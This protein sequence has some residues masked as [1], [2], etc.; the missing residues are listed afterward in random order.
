MDQ[1]NL[2]TLSCQFDFIS[3]DCS[4]IQKGNQT[5]LKRN[6]RGCG[7]RGRLAIW[8]ASAYLFLR[9]L[10][11]NKF[12]IIGTSPAAAASQYSQ[13]NLRW[14]HMLMEI[15]AFFSHFS[16]VQSC[17]FLVA[18]LVGHVL[19]KIQHQHFSLAPVVV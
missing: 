16:P 4:R 15:V 10:I 17:P 9:C 8:Q 14:V 18:S 6:K 1:I 11:N 2:R 3:Q 13:K 7:N 5:K 12:N 19:L